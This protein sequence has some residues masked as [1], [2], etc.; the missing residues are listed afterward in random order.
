M[1]KLL[2]EVIEA[3]NGH[4][5]HALE[6]DTVEVLKSCIA[7]IIDSNGDKYD[8][9]TYKDFFASMSIIACNEEHE[10]DVYGFDVDAFIDSYIW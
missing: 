2:D 8:A 5:C 7:A 4:Y 6:V 10:D 9:A 1:N 3:R